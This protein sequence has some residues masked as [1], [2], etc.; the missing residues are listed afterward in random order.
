MSDLYALRGT[1]LRYHP[2]PQPGRYTWT[3]VSN[4]ASMSSLSGVFSATP[5]APPGWHGKL[6]VHAEDTSQFQNDDGT[7]F[8][9]LG[10]TG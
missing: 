6:R 10:D 7:W 1:H 2:A 9:H 8:L 5:D 4:L 3:S